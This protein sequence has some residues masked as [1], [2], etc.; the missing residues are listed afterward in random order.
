M[1]I[2]FLSEYNNHYTTDFKD[3]S[4]VKVESQRGP[5]HFL[6]VG[7]KSPK[8]KWQHVIRCKVANHLATAD[9]LD[10]KKLQL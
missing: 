4:V 1:P 8:Q 2:F 7:V 6:F 10:L 5:R 3:W 9:L